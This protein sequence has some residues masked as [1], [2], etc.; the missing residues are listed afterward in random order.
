MTKP[1]FV[2]RS[3]E[4]HALNDLL[5]KKTASLVV[6]KGRRRIGKSRLVQ[7]FASNKK[8]YV[9][10]GL[11][12]TENTT[13]Q[14]QRDEFSRQL[15]TQAGLPEISA[16]DWSKLFLLL[17]EKTK[18][19]RVIILF[20]EISWM[21]SKDPDFLGKI[22]NSWDLYL[23][24]NPTLIFILCGSV[25]FW[26]EK[27]IINSTGFLGR[28]SLKLTLDELSLPECNLLL[29]HLGFN[30]SSF[31]KLLILS[32]TGGIPWYI[33]QV[34]PNH[35]SLENIKRLCFEK[36]GLFVDEFRFIFH[37]LFGRRGDICKKIVEYLSEGSAEYSEIV[38][39]LNYHSSGSLS[40][41]LNDLMISGFI[42]RDYVWVLKSG[43]DALRLSKFRLSD[44]YLRFYFKYISPRLSRIRKNQFSDLSL[45]SLPNWDGIMGLQ[46][47]NLV[48]KN[49]KKIHG[50]LGLKAEEIIADNPYYQRKTKKQEA[51]Q[52]DYFIQ[53]RYNTLF[54][55]EIKFSRKEI[56]SSVISEV[57][58]KIEK[59]ALPKD[60]A[61]L[62]VLI[63]ANG[64]SQ[65]IQE[66]NYFFRIINFSEM[67][68]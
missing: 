9:F 51:C 49:R 30:R 53:T 56:N 62:P 61:C 28:I 21:G 45:L 42:S 60:F 20:D 58:K 39:K 33:E 36:E 65:E 29:Q 34:R 67:L 50:I 43:K 3:Q 44:N 54:S 63:H 16:D 13:A 1:P 15:A 23:S 66:S 32:I 48:L 11:P 68:Y 37:D 18:T 2:G 12:P 46:F 5:Q 10:S 55:C 41:Y 47:E 27:N 22:K 14:S 6:I 24:K 17:A 52:I 64:A 25:S 7:E 4:L 31:E 8:Y 19:G 40:E 26:I 35:S 38:S 57:K 59:L